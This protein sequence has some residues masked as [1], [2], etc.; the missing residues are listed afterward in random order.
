MKGTEP[1]DRTTIHN[2]VLL[3]HGPMARAESVQK[4]GPWAVTTP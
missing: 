4:F 3:A 1:Q 2:L